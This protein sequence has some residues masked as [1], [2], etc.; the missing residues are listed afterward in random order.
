[1]RFPEVKC[2]IDTL[3]W[4]E[5][6]FQN[7]RGGLELSLEVLGN[8]FGLPEQKQRA[9]ED[10]LLNL[11]VLKEGVGVLSSILIYN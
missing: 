11:A 7:E 9:V 1:M 10:C 2:E 6:N 5:K 3:T 8:H 4:L